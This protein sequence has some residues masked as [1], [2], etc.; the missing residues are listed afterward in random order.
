MDLFLETACV[1]VVCLFHVFFLCLLMWIRL[2]VRFAF[3][4]LRVYLVCF[5]LL[6]GALG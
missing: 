2:C 5:V 6:F 1:F 3:C 4:D